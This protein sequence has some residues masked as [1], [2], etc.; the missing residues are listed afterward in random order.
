MRYSAWS[1]LVMFV[2]G[3]AMGAGDSASSAAPRASSPAPVSPPSVSSTNASRP[4]STSTTT[5]AARTPTLTRAPGF[6]LSEADPFSTFGADVDTASY[7]IFRRSLLQGALPPSAQVRAEDFIN[8]F[9]YDYPA[10]D[11]ESET[12]FTISLAASAHID[13]ERNTKLL[14]VGIQGAKPSE[15]PPV[16]LVFLVDVSGSM[17]APNKLP[18]VRVVLQET[19]DELRG[20]DTVSI[21]SYAS[22]TRVRLSSTQVRERANIEAVIRK[23]EAAGST[24]GGAGMQLAYKEAESAFRSDGINHIVLCTDGDFN[25]GVTSDDALVELIKQKRRSGVT[26]TAL[27]F[28]ERN[29]DQ[30]M[31]RVSNAGN[32]IYSVLY[33]EDQA[34]AYAH[35]RLL[36]TMFHIAKD[37][38]IQVELNP[39]RVYA[40]RLIGYEDR[41]IADE[42]FRN[43]RID[44]GEVGAGHRVTALYELALAPEDL[45]KNVSA[46]ARQSSSEI[47]AEVGAEDL[48]LVKVRWKQPGAASVDHASELTAALHGDAIESDPEQLD[49]DARWAIGVA[50]LAE[51]L[52]GSS[53]ASRSELPR[54]RAMLESL[55]EGK[56][57]REELVSLLPQVENLTA[58]RR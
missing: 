44:A 22:D 12:P 19:L 15:L 18:L 52:R 24:N 23:L 30:M 11:L 50:R 8:Y 4:A 39:D 26:L 21:V 2:A 41:A 46:A 56:V 13:P 3:C 48:A 7:D 45:P 53:F 57:D 31:E 37:V 5:P 35:Q 51:V 17:A 34:I 28:G 29:N 40:Y 25:L 6:I 14:R 9:T 54:V 33:N 38:K 1:C 32:G 20:D 36:S 43:D 42:Q 27:G 58:G 47:A 10:P 55:A 16:N 49:P